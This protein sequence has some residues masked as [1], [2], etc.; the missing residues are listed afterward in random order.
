[1][2]CELKKQ[3]WFEKLAAKRESQ[4]TRKRRPHPWSQHPWAAATS[5]YV[6]MWA[7]TLF[8]ERAISEW[9]GCV[10]AFHRKD[11]VVETGTPSPL[12]ASAQRFPAAWVSKEGNFQVPLT[13]ALSGME[14][15]VSS[16]T[17]DWKSISFLT[18]PLR[19]VV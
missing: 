15:L 6:S 8:L 17:L 14:F 16:R 7:M 5:S 13:L 3:L 18:L 2:V 9:A 11:C 12:G 19:H 4:Y 10:S 1:M